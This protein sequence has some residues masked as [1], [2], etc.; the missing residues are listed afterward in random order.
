MAEAS[1]AW[2]LSTRVAF[3]FFATYL[4]LYVCSTQMIS[5]MTI[6][7]QVRSPLTTDYDR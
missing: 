7:S 6:D 2:R 1:V 4:T 5:L 3:R